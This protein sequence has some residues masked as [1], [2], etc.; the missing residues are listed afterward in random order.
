MVDFEDLLA[1][2]FAAGLH[3]SKLLLPVWI[4]GADVMTEDELC[5]WY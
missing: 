2:C 5:E 1:G 4:L 3:I